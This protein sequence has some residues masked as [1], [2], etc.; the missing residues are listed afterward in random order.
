MSEMEKL[1]AS[2]LQKQTEADALKASRAA[3]VEQWVKSLDELFGN[4]EK[5]LEPLI[6]NGLVQIQ[7][8][9]GSI[10]ESANTEYEVSYEAP[11]FALV[12]NGKSA[13]IEPKGLYLSG[14][15]GVVRILANQK[16]YFLIR[17]VADDN[18]WSLVDEANRTSKGIPFT[19]DALAHA[20]SHYL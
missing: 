5:W 8:S 1:A 11:V 3:K 15:N 7:R 2:M 18:E 4:I 16:Q 6:K 13:R 9:Y 17:G 19:Q 20:F 14:S 10:K 12:I